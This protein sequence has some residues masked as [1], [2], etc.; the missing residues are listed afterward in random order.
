MLPQIAN[1]FQIWWT[2]AGYEDEAAGFKPII[3]GEIFWMNDNQENHVLA[4]QFIGI[5]RTATISNIE[6]MYEVC[7]GDCSQSPIFWWDCR[8]IARLTINGSHLDFQM[9]RGGGRRGL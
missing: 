3:N 8:D 4:S 1:V 6:C 7:A 9:Y 2:L 5:L